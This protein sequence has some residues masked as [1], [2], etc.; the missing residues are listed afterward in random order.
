MTDEPERLWD[1][2][3]YV[4]RPLIVTVKGASRDEAMARA[5]EAEQWLDQRPGPF[6]DWISHISARGCQ[7]VGTA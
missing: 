1:V 6:G 3:V 5:E 4:E 7:E 2:E